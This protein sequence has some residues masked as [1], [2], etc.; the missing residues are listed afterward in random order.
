MKNL[1]LIFNIVLLAVGIWLFRN[2]YLESK[3]ETEEST[4]NYD[5]SFNHD[6]KEVD[7]QVKAVLS[8]DVIVEHYDGEDKKDYKNGVELNGRVFTTGKAFYEK[9]AGGVEITIPLSNTVIITLDDLT[10]GEHNLADRGNSLMVYEDDKFVSYNSGTV[11]LTEISGGAI[12]G[13]FRSGDVTGKFTGAV[14]PSGMLKDPQD[15]TKTNYL[16]VKS[17]GTVESKLLMSVF[18]YDDSS[19]NLELKTSEGNKSIDAD[20]EKVTVTPTAVTLTA[21]DDDIEYVM[22]D[23]LN[24]D[25]VI[26]QYKNGNSIVLL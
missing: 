15:I 10:A 14:P 6:N 1:R 16:S 12:S 13:S 24:R 4:E 9:T 19:F 21:D 3:T 7:E 8:D 18:S 22:I 26:I 17:D 23:K 25:Q 2:Y 11:S 20:V 5:V